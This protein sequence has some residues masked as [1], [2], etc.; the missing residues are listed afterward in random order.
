M[1]RSD[2]ALV[3][4]PLQQHRIGNANALLSI[5]I[6]AVSCLLLIACF[7][8]SN[9]LLARWSARSGELAV[10]AAI[11]ADR[12]R[13]ARQL[14]TEA[15]LLAFI[16][17][18]MSSFLVV[19]VL[20]GFVRY[21]VHELPRLSEVT[22][23]GRVLGIGVIVSLSAM[24]IATALPVLRAGHIEI[25]R[26]LQ[27]SGRATAEV[28]GQ[29]AKRILVVAE[30]ALSLILL[31]GAALLIET[32]WH[33]RNDRLGFQPERIS[34]IVIPLKGTKLE[35]RNRDELVADLLGFVRRVPGTEGAAQA[36]CTP[37]SGGA[38]WGTFSRSDRPLPEAFHRGNNIHLCGTSAGYA[39]A[40]GVR[41]VRGRFFTDN[42][43]LYPNTLAVINEAAARA[44][45]PGEDP[46]GKQIMGVTD[47]KRKT[48]IG[49]VSDT[50]N[51]GLDSP[52]EPQAFLNG[53]V[54]PASK[55][56]QLIVRSVAD[57][58]ALESALTTEAH[59]LDPS[60]ALTFKS[61]DETIG[62]MTAG[63]RFNGMLI[64]GFAFVAVLMAIIGVYGLLTFTVAQRT[65]EIGIRIAL[66]A[67]RVQILGLVL[68]EG[69]AL[70]FVGI[71]VG[72][73]GSFALTRY[74][75]SIL[76]GVAATDPVTFLAVGIGLIAAALVAI[77]LPARK[78]ASVDPMIALRHY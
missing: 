14:F 54:D 11:G 17:C 36:E 5:L 28:G 76:Y 23:D 67:E 61:L 6:A 60:L 10:R 72:L 65:H 42:D 62:D 45:F 9:L 55:Q 8:V 75:K 16:G 47:G 30:I 78:A 29:L 26:T 7:N 57:R 19:V 37:L 20:H 53:L 2:T 77:L 3:V 33:L 68:R 35:N 63:P 43:T 46:I 38:S 50:K 27:E 71:A 12:G 25:Q 1:F 52:V 22:I 13:I 70:V 4:Q 34:T 21:S 39:K 48:V 56:L 15:G 49:I 18:A 32:L 69:T 40:S 31:S 64:A 59:R 44:Y 51:S 41:V 24:L 73:A 66:G 74:L 58:H